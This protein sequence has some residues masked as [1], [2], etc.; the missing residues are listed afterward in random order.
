[1]IFY[2]KSLNDPMRRSM[3]TIPG[4]SGEFVAWFIRL[5]VNADKALG[6]T[7]LARAGY[8]AGIFDFR[9]RFDSMRDLRGMH[10]TVER[11]HSS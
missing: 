7:L 1:M 6:W 10:Y 2:L 3:I 11:S 9:Q 4:T 8:D 5:A